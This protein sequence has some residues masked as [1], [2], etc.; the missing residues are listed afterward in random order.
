MWSVVSGWWCG[1]ATSCNKKRRR[2]VQAMPYPG[3]LEFKFVVLDSNDFNL[4]LWE[5]G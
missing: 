1:A 2:H 3:R 4:V 5:G